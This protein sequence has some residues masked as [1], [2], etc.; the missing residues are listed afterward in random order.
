MTSQESIG[1]HTLAKGTSVP[2]KRE[3]LWG[4]A[5]GLGNNGSRVDPKDVVS[6]NTMGEITLTGDGHYR[7]EKNF[8]FKNTNGK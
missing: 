8:K 6:R 7:A 4:C 3:I 2:G 5:T 1:G